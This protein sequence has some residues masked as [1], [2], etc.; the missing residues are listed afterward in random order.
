MVAS[1][2]S[3]AFTLQSPE[4]LIFMRT[5]F[6]GSHRSVVEAV[7]SELAHGGSVDGYV[8]D[9]LAI[10]EPELTKATRIVRKSDKFGFP[11]IVSNKMSNSKDVMEMNKVLIQMEQDPDGRDLLKRLNIDGF[12]IAKPELYYGIAEMAKIVEQVK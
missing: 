12:T 8:W 5:F 4:P 2:R 7:A 1:R 10:F 11:P 6:T 9:T 3:I